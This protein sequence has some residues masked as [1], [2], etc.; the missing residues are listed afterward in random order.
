AEVSKRRGRRRRPLCR[1]DTPSTIV[2]QA[3]ATF[4]QS[5]KPPHR[6]RRR[7]GQRARR[8]ASALRRRLASSLCSVKRH[9]FDAFVRAR[10]MAIALTEGGGCDYCSC[11]LLG[12]LGET[13]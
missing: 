2:A 9:I 4:N 12:P 3:R 5:L 7:R 11:T 10:G 6:G 1:R 13:G 8:F